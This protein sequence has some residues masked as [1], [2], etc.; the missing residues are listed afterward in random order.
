MHPLRSLRGQRSRAYIQ[1][2]LFVQSGKGRKQLEQRC[3]L[4][5]TKFLSSIVYSSRAIRDTCTIYVVCMYYVCTHTMY[6][7]FGSGSLGP[8]VP[9]PGS[10]G[11]LNIAS[12]QFY[13]H[14]GYQ[15]TRAERYCD[16]RDSFF[17]FLLLLLNCNTPQQEGQWEHKP[18][19]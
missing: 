12:L 14:A 18:Y 4:L 16:N 15:R 3:H 5:Y 9:S 17:F 2:T 7:I 1:F 10:L 6:T 13:S 8:R 11:P 19:K